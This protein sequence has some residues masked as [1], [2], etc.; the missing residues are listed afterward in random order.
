MENYSDPQSPTKAMLFNPEDNKPSAQ[1]SQ[2]STLPY[3]LLI[4]HATRHKNPTNIH[5]LSYHP[6]PQQNLQPKRKEKRTLF[7]L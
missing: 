6:N 3:F 5:M 1:I 4:Q 7:S 2:L